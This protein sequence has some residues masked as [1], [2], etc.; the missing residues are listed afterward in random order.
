MGPRLVPATYA[1]LTYTKRS[2][3]GRARATASTFCVPTTLPS[4]IA[5]TSRSSKLVDAA[6]CHTSFTE[7]RADD[8][9]GEKP[10]FGWQMSP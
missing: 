5:A 9:A 10:S 8:S 4:W 3:R 7:A 2:S 1:V 6:R